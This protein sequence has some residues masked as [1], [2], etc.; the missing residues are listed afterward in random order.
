MSIQFPEIL[1]HNSSCSSTNFFNIIILT[2]SK[3]RYICIKHITKRC[4]KRDKH[5]KIFIFSTN[6]LKRFLFPIVSCLMILFTLYTWK[7]PTILAVKNLTSHQILYRGDP[8]D[9]KIA[10]T[11][12]IDQ[13]AGNISPL[14]SLLKKNQI[15]Q[16]TFFVSTTYASHSPKMVQK[17][18]DMGYEVGWLGDRAANY[19]KMSRLKIAKTFEQGQA[20]LKK[21]GVK[22]VRWI[23]LPN[24]PYTENILD[25]AKQFDF[26]IVHSS[27]NTDEFYTKQLRTH[28][29]NTT[30]RFKNGDILSFDYTVPTI[31]LHDNLNRFLPI[32]KK[33]GYTYIS[34]TE[35][36]TNLGFETKEIQ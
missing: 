29:L 16:A 4:R 9:Q 25:I 10:L 19:E 34:V 33:A 7:H 27:V 21:S 13:N 15:K 3:N 17:M 23:R 36:V 2:Y 12:N 14:L 26:T 35:L 6:R 24:E 31:I 28:A 18:I 30:K 1:Y 22:E 20:L 8:S 32:L 5:M 11:F